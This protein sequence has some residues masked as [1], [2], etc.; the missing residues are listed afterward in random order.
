MVTKGIFSVVSFRVFWG[1][2]Q[3]NKKSENIL[4]EKELQSGSLN[5]SSPEAFKI[6]QAE[7]IFTRQRLTHQNTCYHALVEGVDNGVRIT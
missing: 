6:V 7:I 3:C 4:Y 1:W 5:Y 2:Y